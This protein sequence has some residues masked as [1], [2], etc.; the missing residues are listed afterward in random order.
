MDVKIAEILQA[1]KGRAAQ[2]LLE[3]LEVGR[4]STDTRAL[5]KNDVFLALS[6]PNF[7]GHDFVADA[8]EKGAKHFVISDPKKAPKGECNVI[9]V[10]DVLAAY[11]DLAAYWRHKFNIPA[12]AITG[13]SGKTTVKELIAHILSSKFSVLKNRGTENNL[14]GVPKTILQL[15]PSHDMMVLE[16]GTNQ[17]G[18][19]ARLSSIVSPQVGV[20]TLIGHSHLEG[21]K[22]VEG[23]YAEK[24]SLLSSLERGGTLFLN[25]ED[26]MLKKAS[27]GAHRVLRAGF[28]KEGNQFYAENIWCHETGSSFHLNG[29]DLFEIPLLGKHNIL[30]ALLAIS[31]GATLGLGVEDMRKSLKEFKPISGRLHMKNFEGITFIDDSYNS[32]PASF[33]AALE[34]LKGFRIRGK[35]GV[36]F[37]D[38]LE[39]GGMGEELHRDI[40]TLLSTL[41]FDFVIATGPLSHLAADEAVKR[42]LSAS[43]IS[44]AKNSSEA[45]ALCR[46]MV[47]AGDMVLVKGSRGMKMEKVFECFTL[48]STP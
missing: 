7:D 48:S 36:V 25:G 16:I 4:I 44:L 39:L 6:G 12:V 38:M 5:G 8:L 32:N 34:A 47:S 9:L 23:V 15:E 42:G 10:D 26:L 18:E 24:L 40:G 2:P 1:V 46:K 3:N 45:G 17:P 41:Y 30:N 33:R 29:K 14:V 35:K 27:S 11:G 21:L 13:S 28:G 22:S 43:K 37:G 20:I 19:I 31:V